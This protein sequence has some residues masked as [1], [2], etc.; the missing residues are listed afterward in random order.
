META[1]DSNFRTDEDVRRFIR[2]MEPAYQ[3]TCYCISLAVNYSLKYPIN[4]SASIYS[5]SSLTEFEENRHTVILKENF[6]VHRPNSFD[7][8]HNGMSTLIIL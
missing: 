2:S 5:S 8:P 4:F 6:P 1:A 7:T 3:T